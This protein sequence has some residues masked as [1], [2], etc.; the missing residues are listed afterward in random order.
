MAD[1]NDFQHPDVVD[2]KDYKDAKLNKGVVTV[3]V[4]A[5]SIVVLNIK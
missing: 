2:P 1:Y 3:K 5:K 4:P